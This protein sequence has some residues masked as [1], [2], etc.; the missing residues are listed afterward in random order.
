MPII[1]K[2][3]KKNELKTT[4]KPIILKNYKKTSIFNP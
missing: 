3:H 4:K 2:H 1:K